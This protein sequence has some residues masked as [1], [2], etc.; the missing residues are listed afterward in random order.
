M[1]NGKIK[2]VGLDTPSID[3]GQSSDF[4]THRI[5]LAKDIPAFENVANLELLPVKNIY[6][7]ALPMLLKDGS[8]APLRIIAGVKDWIYKA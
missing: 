6:V 1:I 8:G 2:A 5:L 3:Y 4:Q 7:V